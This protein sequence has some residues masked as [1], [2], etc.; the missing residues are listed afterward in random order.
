[1]IEPSLTMEAQLV[2]WSVLLGL[3]IAGLAF[4]AWREEQRRVSEEMERREKIKGE[5]RN[6][7]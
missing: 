4:G 6:G 7:D 5:L 3:L 2:G 1:M